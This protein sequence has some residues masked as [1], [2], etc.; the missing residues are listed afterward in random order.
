VRYLSKTIHYENC[1]PV[2]L[3]LFGD[4]HDGSA[5]FSRSNFKKFL[6]ESMDHPNAHLIGMGDQLDALIPSD[7]KRFQMSALDPKFLAAEHPDEIL[8]LQAADFI[9][10]LEPYRGHLIGLVEGNHEEIIRKKHGFSIHRHICTQLNC[11]NLGRSFLML[12]KLTDPKHGRTRSVTIYG[13]HGFGGGSR[14]EGGSITKYARLISHYDADL[15]IT[16]HDHDF[17]LKKVARIGINGNGKMQHKNVVLANT[18]AFKKSLSDS[19]TPSWEETK[20]F[21]PRLLG[22]L[23]LDMKPEKN[24]WV[25]IKGIE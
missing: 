9:S 11:E 23:V 13:H 18:G 10:L 6:S 15:Y 22:G 4:T 20:G 7:T 5:H 3:V 17:W 12:M 14:T 24:G 21:P 16:A 1:N 25:D 8:D 2:R 19:D